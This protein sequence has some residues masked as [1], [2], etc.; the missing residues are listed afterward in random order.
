MVAAQERIG[1]REEG[2]SAGTERAESRAGGAGESVGLA[3]GAVE[4]KQAGVGGFAG[5]LVLADAFPEFFLG[6]DNVENVIDDLKGQ[7]QSP[8]E[9]REVGKSAGIGPGRH[10]AQ[11]EGSGDEGASLGAV[12]L[13][14]FLQRDAFLLRIQIENLTGDEAEAAGGMGEF[15]DE[16]SPGVAAIELGAGHGGERLSEEAVPGQHGDGFTKHLVVGGTSPAKIIIIHAGQVVVD[17]E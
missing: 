13:D 12:N 3:A 15:G 11:A 4:S 9:L 2:V 8:A 7:A 17:E 1:N 10:G 6:G 16:V 14:E 5:G